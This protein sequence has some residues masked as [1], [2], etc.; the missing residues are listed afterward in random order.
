MDEILDNFEAEHSAAERTYELASK[1]QRFA[2]Y[3]IDVIVYY[4]LSFFMGIMLGAVLLSSNN[5][6]FLYE[7]SV[8]LSI[9]EY[10]IGILAFLI[11]YTLTEYFFQGKTLGKLITKTRAVNDDNGNMSFTTILLRSLSRLVPFE[12]FSF[13]GTLPLGWH[14]TWTSTKVIKDDNWID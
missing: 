10:L 7:E 2:N 4:S 13:L 11:Y 5:E 14:D 1:G 3:M 8:E 6:D 12:P 9:L